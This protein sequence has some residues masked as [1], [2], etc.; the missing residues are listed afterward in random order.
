MRMRVHTKSVRFGMLA[1]AAA[2]VLLPASTS[3]A[4]LFS[5]TATQLEA[6]GV[7]PFNDQSSLTSIVANPNGPGVILTGQFGTNDIGPDSGDQLPVQYAGPGSPGL[8]GSD[9]NLLGPDSGFTGASLNFQVLSITATGNSPGTTTAV[10]QTLDVGLY[11]QSRGDN[12]DFNNTGSYESDL[13]VGAGPTTSTVLWSNFTN[14]DSADAIDSFQF[15]FQIYPDD[16]GTDDAGDQAGAQFQILITSTTS[17]NAWNLQGYGN[18]NNS[19]AWGGQVVPNGV[20]AEADFFGSISAPSSVTTDTAITLGTIHFN[21]ANEYVLGGAGSLTL[22]AAVGNDALVQVDQGTDEINLP[23]TI[24]SDTTFNVA[25]GAT[26]VIG[27]PLTINAG[28]SLT[29]TGGGT[30]TYNSIVSV[31]SGSSLSIGNPT[32]GNA[33]NL[34]STAHVSLTPTSGTPNVVQFNS[35]SLGAGASLDLA[36]NTFVVNYASGADPAA[37]IASELAAGYAADWSGAGIYSSTVASLNA[38][39]SALIYA[40][41]YADGSDGIT[42]VPSGKI[43]ILPTLAGDAKLQGNVVFGDFQLLS[44]YFGQ[45][46]TTWDEGNFTYGSTT[47]FGDFQLLSQNFGQTASGLTAGELAS[48]NSFASQFGDKVV[49]D[50]VG[51]QVVSVPEPMSAGLLGFGALG[52]MARRRSRSAR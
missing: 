13:A 45:P 25:G 27:N 36:N 20:G 21:N 32:I 8:Q 9:L 19:E 41:G 11:D 47:N 39:Q 50:G 7:A 33:L 26:L 10:T 4:Q 18:Y 34:A 44:Q 35:L 30:V 12:Y 24:A 43:E 46:N 23:T 42:S 22:Q 52:L 38:S 17:A 48:L 40:V 5:P 51:F 14:G 1:A 3:M 6:F 49:S 16:D 15:G 37:S 28:L 31:G 2:A 29:Q